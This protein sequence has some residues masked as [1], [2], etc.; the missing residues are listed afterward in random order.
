MSEAPTITIAGAVYQKNPDVDRYQIDV[1]ALGDFR[2]ED[3][4]PHSHVEITGL[5]C[6]A[7]ACECEVFGVNSGDELSVYGGVSYR[8]TD[9]QKA[10]VLARLRRAFPDSFGYVDAFG[11]IRNPQ[12]SVRVLPDGVLASVTMCRVY[13]VHSDV[14]LR[15]AAIPYVEGL[16][17]LVSPQPHVFICHASE[18]KGSARW[19]SRALQ[20]AG[21][22][23]WLDE[24]EIQ[25]GD[26][27]L[28]KIDQALGVVTHLV[29]LLSW[30]SIQRPWVRKELS[31][32]LFRQLD[33]HSICVLPVRLD[34]CPV[35]PILADIKY[36]DGRASPGDAVTALLA[37]LE[38]QRAG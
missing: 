26:S 23:V 4:P 1:D 20:D 19:I 17:R 22:D 5:P 33:G 13:E 35:P 36:A 29:V 10:G 18:D 25:V 28:D 16:R 21:A 11:H 9:A 31:S 3:I 27:I 15:E 7:D 37:A 8:T 24:W 2:L 34:D 12:F 32:A 14:L 6:P 38:N 30:T